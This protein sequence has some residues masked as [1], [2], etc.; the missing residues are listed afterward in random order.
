MKQYQGGHDETWG[1]VTINIDRNW[2][3]LGEGSTAAKEADH[4]GGVR[5]NFPDYPTLKAPTTAA[6]GSVTAPDA[7]LVSALQCRL[8]Q[9]GLYTGAINGRYTTRT[10]AAVN[11]W[12][13]RTEAPTR[14]S[15][16]RRNWMSL[17]AQGQQKVQK[18]GLTGPLVRRVQRALNAWSTDSQI[19]VTGVF[20]GKTE[21]AVQAYQQAVGLRSGG[22]VD[23]LTWTSLKE[24]VRRR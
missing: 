3:D 1:G 6:D 8:T 13:A 4:C 24:G 20:D 7:R 10:L 21:R 17:L 16:T 18:R 23:A 22:V 15:F 11:A 5:I 19:V 14:T 9:V 2:L 12:Q